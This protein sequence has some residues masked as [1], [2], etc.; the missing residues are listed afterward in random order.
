MKAPPYRGPAIC[1][2]S[3][4]AFRR[5]GSMRD[6][7]V[8]YVEDDPALRAIMSKLLHSQDG[9]DVVANV[10]NSHEALEC[11]QTSQIDVALLDIALGH[12]SAT[13]QEL[14]LQLRSIN[15]NIGIV[16]YSQHAEVNFLSQLSARNL[17]GWS[18]IQKSASI[19]MPYLVDVLRSTARGLSII[20]PKILETERSESS[21][22]FEQL[23]PRQH[24]IMALIVEGI[25]VPH[26]SEKLGVSAVTIRQELSRIY[27]VIV[28]EPAPGT[29]LRTTAVLRYL[30]RSRSY[31]WTHGE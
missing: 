18:T 14:A 6:T 31:A 29:D 21:T 1:C 3:E 2:K 9:I 22:E 25:D 8:L 16:I 20:D 30:R 12:N 19:D 17:E 11:A 13:G 7:R 26:I 28:P 10:G 24:E 23:T 5:E 27:K 4:S 15:S